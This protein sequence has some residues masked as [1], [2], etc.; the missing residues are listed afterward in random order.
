VNTIRFRAGLAASLALVAGACVS[1]PAFGPQFYAID[2]PELRVPPPT[3]GARVVSVDRVVVA[4]QVAGRAL[5]YRTAPHGFERDPYATL[6]AAPRELVE[7]VLRAS[8]ANVD[9]VSQVVELGGPVAPEILVEA[10]VT[11][12]QG[13]FTVPDKPTAVLGMELVVMVLPPAPAGAS[14]VLRK[15]YLRQQP[16]PERS[17]SAV[18]NAWNQELTSIVQEFLADMR[19]ALPPAP[20]PVTGRPR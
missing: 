3:P 11:D 17:A 16:I 10:Y 5:T 12:L 19:S 18:A 20:A 4:P 14:V 15:S 7:A 1:K 8:L 2:P 9:F 6:A 13:D